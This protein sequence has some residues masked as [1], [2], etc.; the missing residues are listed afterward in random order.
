[1]RS[2]PTVARVLLRFILIM[3]R[4]PILAI[5]VAVATGVAIAAVSET[6]HAAPAVAAPKVGV[7]A[8]FYPVAFAAQTVG[9]TTSS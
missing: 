7:A 2:I 5:A 8:S 1:M 4:R 9:R 6:R 3:R